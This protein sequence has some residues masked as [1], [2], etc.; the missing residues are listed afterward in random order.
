MHTDK[1]FIINPAT[2]AKKR[3]IVHFDFMVAITGV[4]FCNCLDL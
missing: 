3:T 2:F 4:W 1:L